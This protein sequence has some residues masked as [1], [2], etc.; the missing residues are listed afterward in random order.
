[1][2]LFS[3]I[4]LSMPPPVLLTTQLVATKKIFLLAALIM[5]LNQ[6]IHC[7][8]TFQTT[9]MT[10]VLEQEQATFKSSELEVSNSLTDILCLH[11]IKIEFEIDLKYLIYQPPNGL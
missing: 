2:L 8:I 9:I 3:G 7:L 1:M 6:L 4:K 11:M 5:V 10:R